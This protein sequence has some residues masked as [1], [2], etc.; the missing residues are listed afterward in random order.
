MELSKTFRDNIT[1]LFE[2]YSFSNHF[3]ELLDIMKTQDDTQHYS[4]T[5][6]FLNLFEMST[7]LGDA[8]L[9]NSVLV[10]GLCDKAL[11]KVQYMIRDTSDDETK[12]TLLVKDKIHAR[13][14]ALPVCPEL[15]RVK[16]PL[17]E[18]INNFLCVTGTVVRTAAAKMLEYQRD[19]ICL[20]C[21]KRFTV[22]AAYEKM[23]ILSG[24]TKC[25]NEDCP[26]TNFTPVKTIE[27]VN[28]KDY[29]E[30]KM[31]EQVGKLG[32]G[33]M[34]R[35]MWATLEDDLVD[36]CKPGDD[37]V[38]CGTVRRRWRPFS[39]GARIDCELALQ[40]N[41]ISVCNDQ[42]SSVLLS[43]EV[44]AE[45]VEFWKKN[46]LHRLA[47]RNLIL[48]SIAPQIYGLYLV[49][50]AVAVVLAGGVQ[51]KEMSGC[52]I[53]AESHLLL[54]GDPGTGKS[55]ILRFASKVCPRSV[56]TTGVGSTTAGLTVA[57]VREN[58]EWQLEAGALVLSDGGICCID[59]FNSIR[60]QDKTSIHEAMEQQTLSVA[61]AG[62]V[63]K[64][65]T[66]CS[67]LAATNP[68]GDYDPNVN[69]SVNT[70]L[71]SPL[72]S[73]FDLVLVLKDAHDRAWDDIVAMFILEGKRPGTGKDTSLWELEK[74]QSYFSLIKRLEPELS[75]DANAILSRYYQMQRK[76]D[77]R[78]KARTTVRLL[79]SL[80]RLSQAHAKLMFREK[81]LVQD[82]VVA[83]CLIEASMQGSA[84]ICEINALQTMFP[85]D[86]DEEYKNQATM[87]LQKLELY[88]ILAEEMESFHNQAD[89][90]PIPFEFDKRSSLF[91][92][93]ALKTNNEVASMD[94]LRKKALSKKRKLSKMD[95]GDESCSSIEEENT[96]AP[97]K[98]RFG[99][100]LSCE[101]EISIDDSSKNEEVCSDKRSSLLQDKMGTNGENKSRFSL[102]LSSD[103]ESLPEDTSGSNKGSKYFM[104]SEF[105]KSTSCTPRDIEGEDI[106][107]KRSRF[108]LSLSSDDDIFSDDLSRNPPEQKKNGKG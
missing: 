73:R 28:Y 58:G 79:E 26:S 23:Y 107:Q 70:A 7:E 25:E 87:V 91:R 16:F 13:M 66:R 27:C 62:L 93:A 31:Q 43:N 76:A 54:V 60:Q 90:N 41:H 48:A 95:S 106:G 56:F 32:M 40:V 14:T 81:V 97:Q 52:K 99:L 65:S 57:A 59:E 12:K 75:A 2:E 34:P 5:I 105:E 33:V 30:I 88:D 92:N 61:K 94:E 68:K 21:K 50:L 69:I 22:K 96:L 85:P 35:S 86:P 37:I 17:N 74:L 67:I 102:K 38:V 53:R 6:N 83:V 3:G 100:V 1:K 51:K 78:N 104:E 89:D 19:Y 15:H 45:F 80:I 64:L 71:A 24:P 36:T 108:D 49:K 72:L 103:E 20:K 63:C 55:D 42:R 29:Q 18:D 77:V 101:E 9:S 44:K 10:L 8:V 47:A 82:A 11:V 84:L 46:A 98:S 39:Q 4:L